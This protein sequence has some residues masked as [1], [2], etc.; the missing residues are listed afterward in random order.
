M[1][2]GFTLLEAL[3]TTLILV[4]GLVSVAFLFTFSEQT[5]LANQERTAA[6]ILLQDKMEELSSAPWNSPAWNTGGSLDPSR[7]A[8]GFID[9][10]S[11]DHTTFLRI[12]EIQGLSSRTATV[13]VYS[14]HSAQT[15]RLTEMSWASTRISP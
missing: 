4:F 13:V 8:P 10:I 3:I 11:T 12:W 7:P 5:N 9:Y 1:N 14:L 15:R 2:R 6:T